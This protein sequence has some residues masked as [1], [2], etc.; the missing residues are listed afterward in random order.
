MNSMNS[1]KKIVGCFEAKTNFN[2][3]INNVINGEEILVT[4][5]GKPVAKIIPIDKS[6]NFERVNNAFLRLDNLAKEMNLGKF[7]WEEFKS[8][9]DEGK[10]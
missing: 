6:I 7:N 8:Y 4:K 3:I 5:R 2:R 1:M 10:K 9:R